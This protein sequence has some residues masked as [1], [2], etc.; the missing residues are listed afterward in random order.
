MKNKSTLD[1]SPIKLVFLLFH[2]VLRKVKASIH[3]VSQLKGGVSISCTLKKIIHYCHYN[4]SHFTL[5]LFHLMI[6]NLYKI[7]K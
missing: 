3:N 4:I 5:R 1:T 7:A 6:Y 2:L